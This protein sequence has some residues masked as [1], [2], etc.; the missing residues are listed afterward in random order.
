MRKIKEVLRLRSLGLQQHQIARSCS[1]AQ[2]TV[3]EYVKAVE[4]AGI[5]WP[6]P[7]D[8]DGRQ[9]EQVLF[10]A[11]PE[12]GFS[13]HPPGAAKPQAPHPAV[14]LGRVPGSDSGAK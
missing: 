2:S 5:G 12:A 7:A 11:R 4:A 9:L 13:R 3:Q 6:L 1:I 14:G 10:P 8:G